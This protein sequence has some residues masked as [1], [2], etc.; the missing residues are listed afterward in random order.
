MRFF[1][2]IERKIRR[3]AARN[4]QLSEARFNATA[5]ERVVRKDL[6]CLNDVIRSLLCKRNIG[7]QQ[8]VDQTFEISKGPR[9]VDYLRQDL[10]S[11]NAAARP[12]TFFFRYS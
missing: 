2:A 9:R 11:G 12:R 6:Y 3:F 4:Y 7:L 10:A 1:I 8:K 5:N